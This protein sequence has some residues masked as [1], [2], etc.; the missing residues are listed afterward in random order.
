DTQP[1]FHLIRESL[2]ALFGILSGERCH[3]WGYQLEVLIFVF[4]LAYGTSYRVVAVAFSVPLTTVH[5]AVH[6][7]AEELMEILLQ[8]IKLPKQEEL[9]AVGEGFGQLTNYQAFQKAVGATSVL[10]L[11]ARPLRSAIST[12]CYI[13]I[14]SSKAYAA[15]LD[16]S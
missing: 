14:F 2:N 6:N 10:K 7:I 13:I 1:H 8:I 3:G 12:G 16:G 4:C 15:T 5:R 9:S 11:Q